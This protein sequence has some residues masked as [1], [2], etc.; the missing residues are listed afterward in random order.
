MTFPTVQVNQKNR[1]QGEVGEVERH[2]L[3]IGKATKNQGKVL[4]VNTQTDFDVQ[5]GTEASLLKSNLL[6]AMLNAGQN[7]TAAVY[8]LADDETDWTVGAR[9]AQETQSFEGIAVCEPIKAKA[10]VSAAQTFRSQMIATLGRWQFVALTTAL[11]AEQAWSD[12]EAV[13][14]G[15]QDTIAAD[16]V[17]IIPAVWTDALGKLMGRLSN[18][19]VSI[20]DSPCRVMTG[21]LIGDV[22]L[23]M[24]KDGVTLQLA[25]LQTLEKN[26]LSVPM[27]YPDVDGLYWADGRMLDVEGGDYQVVEYRRVMDKVARVMRIRAVTRIGD[28]NF[29]SMPQSMASAKMYFMRDLKVMGKA[30]TVNGELFVGDIMPPKDE[31]IT[32]A[33]KTKT[34]VELYITA[35]PTDC[36]KK[37]TINLMLDLSNPGGN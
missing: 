32:I 4:S 6:A 2:F 34:E 24:D 10:E 16:G 1:M 26:R 21:A 8:V 5:L 15:L 28:R 18:R 17:M 31:D 3:F 13:M 11:I 29:N 27:W 25:T 37:I 7:W 23:P 35:Q 9:K 30:T 19:S 14:V 36:P 20:A 33:W 12:W 22:T